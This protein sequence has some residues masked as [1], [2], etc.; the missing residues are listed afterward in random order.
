MAKNEIRAYESSHVCLRVLSVC[1]KWVGCRRGWGGKY[2]FSKRG[3]RVG[4][5]RFMPA[6]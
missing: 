3:A 1:V 5:Y 2:G 6:L 4:A